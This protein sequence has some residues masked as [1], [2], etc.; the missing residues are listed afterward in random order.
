MKRLLFYLLCLVLAACSVEVPT[1]QKVLPQL[2]DIYPDYLGV[3]IPANIAPLRFKL[4]HETEEAVAV[5]SRGDQQLVEPGKDGKFLFGE[6]QWAD[7][8]KGAEGDS[9]QVTVYEKQQGTW[10]AY[11]AFSLYVAPEPVDTHLAYRLIYPGYEPWYD[12]GIYQRDLTTY[13]EKCIL[14]NKQT[15][16]NCMNCHSFCLQNPDQMMFHMRAVHGG[17]YLVQNGN[18]EVLDGKVNDDIASLVYPSWHPSGKFIAFSTNKTFQAFHRQDK[19]RIEVYD[20]KSDVLVYDVDRHEV[21]TD[22]L[23]FSPK[24]FETFPTFSPDGKTLY[25]CSAEADTLQLPR[26]MKQVRY[27]LC[28]IAFNPES[29]TFG[30]QVDTLYNARTEGRS[31]KFPRV[32]PDGKYLVFTLSDYGN[33]SIWHH[34]ADLFIYDLNKHSYVAMEEANSQDTESY[35]SWGSNSRWM[36]FGSRRD[37]GLYTRPY[38]C[39]IPEDGQARKAFMVPQE[40]PDFYRDFLYSYN[41]PE[42]IK[43]EV[44]VSSK[45]LVDAANHS[46]PQTIHLKK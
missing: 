12:L 13:Q 30:T 46:T 31:A 1:A 3:T 17:T 5:L 39:Y 18:V 9:L 40:D 4:T 16:N 38:I 41:I 25:F 24:A 7:L 36:V 2:P 15:D 14:N 37:D 33:F 6:S 42:F 44:K 29:R 26:D 8:L 45:T 11:A 22:S 28:S 34:D 32:S 10:V 21:L 19:N 43:G 27:S 35:H 23:L 20:E